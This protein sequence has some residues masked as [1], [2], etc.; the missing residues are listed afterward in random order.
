MKDRNTVSADERRVGKVIACSDCLRTDRLDWSLFAIAPHRIGRNKFLDSQLY[1]PHPK[2][3]AGPIA[4]DQTL[5][6]LAR[7]SRR[8]TGL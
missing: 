2:D 6:F 1:P 4:F 7:T 3:I 5:V 8:G